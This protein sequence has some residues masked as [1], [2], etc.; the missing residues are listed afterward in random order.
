TQTPPS[1]AGPAKL[2]KRSAKG[3]IQGFGNV[4]SFTAKFL[5]MR[6]YRVVGISDV[7]GMIYDPDGIDVPRLMMDMRGK[8]VIADLKKD[9]RGG[10]GGSSESRYR[11]RDKEEIFEID[12]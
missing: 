4:G 11:I 5:H 2:H 9:G 1:S 8:D 10:G 6:G 3:S 7:S 12:S